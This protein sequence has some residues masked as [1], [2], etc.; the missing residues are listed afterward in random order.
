MR[1]EASPSLVYGAGLLIPLG[2]FG[3]RGFE[4]LCLRH[5]RISTTL[6]W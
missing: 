1:L 4:S 3:P 6:R 2:R 5:N